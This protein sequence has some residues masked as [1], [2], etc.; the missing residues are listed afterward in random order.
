MMNASPVTPVSDA[1]FTLTLALLLV[2]PLAIAG[3]ALLNTGL[4]RS[5]SAAQSLLGCVTMIGVAA[6]AFAM[7]G[8]SFAGQ[9]GHA[10]RIAAKPW[11]WIGAAPLF[12][13]HFSA[14]SPQSQLEV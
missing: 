10:M 7:V 14:A 9:P 4:G 8:V 12:L 2:A 6:I 5:R 1:L 11:E 3:V 13:R